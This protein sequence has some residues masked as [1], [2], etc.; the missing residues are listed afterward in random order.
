ML[1]QV[2][3][4]E[5][6]R[7]SLVKPLVETVKIQATKD[8]YDELDDLLERPRSVLVR[9]DYLEPFHEQLPLSHTQMSEVRVSPSRSVGSVS[10]TNDLSVVPSEV[11]LSLDIADA[12]TCDVLFEEEIIPAPPA[13]VH[14][15]PP[16]P[17]FDSTELLTIEENWP[18][19]V[20]AMDDVEM[21][22]LYPTVIELELYKAKE[23][24]VDLRECEDEIIPQSSGQVYRPPPPNWPEERI[25]SPVA[26]DESILELKDLATATMIQMEV[27]GA[28]LEKAIAVEEDIYMVEE[29]EFVVEARVDLEK[30]VAAEEDIYTVEEE[31]FVVEASVDLEQ[32]MRMTERELMIT[33]ERPVSPVQDEAVFVEPLSVD[34]ELGSIDAVDH[35]ELPLNHAKVDECDLYY[36]EEESYCVDVVCDMKQ[37]IQQQT[38]L[39]EHSSSQFSVEEH[40]SPETVKVQSEWSVSGT[41]AEPSMIKPIEVDV[42]AKDRS[43]ETF[44]LP[45]VIVEHADATTPLSPLP[46]DVI[47]TSSSEPSVFGSALSDEC[48]IYTH[49]EEMFSESTLEETTTTFEQRRD[50]LQ[51]QESRFDQRPEAEEEEIF[52]EVVVEQKSEF[53]SQQEEVIEEV[54]VEEK[55]ALESEARQHLEVPEDDIEMYSSGE[56]TFDSWTVETYRMYVETRKVEA[57]VTFRRKQ[58]QQQE[59]QL[60]VAAVDASHGMLLNRRS[61]Y[62]HACTVYIILLHN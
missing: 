59:Q 3:R 54:V 10:P 47:A 1:D 36:Y 37:L 62:I 33:E 56:E 25:A 21:L 52:E 57:D 26:F 29:E 12:S 39:I 17:S 9:T 40:Y 23:T 48:T 34:V 35:P 20:S 45:Q 61:I 27:E 13:L 19:A 18:E 4:V 41:S 43:S 22:S 6:A 7:L 51:Q 31:E 42:A 8:L 11:E 53:E 16:L 50:A 55:R 2:A 5:A 49:D 58:Q 38:Q 46:A 60:A 44:V 30:A 32:I 24:E 28:V 15:P 14:R